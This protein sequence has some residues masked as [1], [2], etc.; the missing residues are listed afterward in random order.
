MQGE[1]VANVHY[2]PVD[3]KEKVENHRGTDVQRKGVGDLEV[4]YGG[5]R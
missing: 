4:S 3:K 5:Q 2:C 1:I